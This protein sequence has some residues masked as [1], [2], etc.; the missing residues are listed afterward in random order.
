MKEE[1]LFLDSIDELNDVVEVVPEKLSPGELMLG[2]VV[3]IDEHGQFMVSFDGLVNKKGI[4]AISTI[5]VEPRLIGRQVVLM[6]AA[7]DISQPI[8]AGFLRNSLMDM[9]DTVEL[10]PGGDTEAEPESRSL[11]VDSTKVVM[12][13]EEELVLKCGE[14]SITLLKSGKILIRGKYLVSRSSGVNRILGG[15]IQLN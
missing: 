6:F 10:K 11:S 12:E 15:S 9:F 13:A 7:Q 14:S 1:T 5:G 4:P 8:V 3:S 2:Q